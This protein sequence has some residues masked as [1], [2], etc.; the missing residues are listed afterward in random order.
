[1]QPVTVNYA[2]ANGTATAGSDYTAASGSVTFA[3]GQ[4]TATVTINVTGETY[5]EP[6]E[7][8]ALAL[9][10]PA[11]TNATLGTTSVTG[12]ILNDDYAPVANAGPDKTANE[13]GAVGFDAS[14]SSDADGDPLTFTWNF[15][16][17]ATGSGVAASHAYADDGVYTVTL[18]ADDGHGGL[19]TDTALVTVKNVAPTAAVS[20]PASG[21]RGQARTFTFSAT[22]PSPVDQAAGFTY[23]VN[24]GDGTS[25]TTTGS[26]SGVILT[27]VYTSAAT[28]NVSVTATDGDGAQGAAAA[29][30]VAVKAVELQGTDLVVGGT[31]GPDQIVLKATS[32][33]GVQVLI[34]GQSQG[35]FSP[36]G[37]I[38]V[39]AQ[40]GDDSV[41]FQTTKSGG[42]TYAVARPLLLFGGD[43]N[44]TLD[45]RTATGPAVLVGGAGNDTLYGGSGR[46][47]L[48][49]GAGGD[50]INGG[51]DDDIVI[52]GTTTYDNDLAALAA[53]RA[54]WART[55]MSYSL[56]V[57]HLRD[58]TVGGLN[59]SYR[60]NGTTVID[61]GVLDD[62]YGNGGQDWF[63]AGP[64]DRV[65]DKKNNETLTQ[66]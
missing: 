41:T 44:D 34:G 48:I 21:V 8:F 42:T 31:T 15:G 11:G 60:L 56:R 28:F 35:T 14:G 4:T 13:G 63:F 59:G 10:L 32:A 64:N 66:L 9:S 22:D 12:T 29:A 39:Y 58:G 2:T 33:A 47:I 36:T 16:D 5:L 46:A 55:D 23:A 20:G 38:V 65:N 18:T 19:S 52:G 50:T 45:A 1:V 57:G 54:E 51:T 24:W 26:G 40:A 62:L 6:D 49:G 27:H 37:Q 43:G 61:D 30:L 3:P 53:L 7:T 25:S 17:G